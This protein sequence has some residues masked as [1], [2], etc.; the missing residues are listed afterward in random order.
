MLQVSQAFLRHGYGKLTMVELAKECGFTRRALYYYFNSKEE[1][2]RATVRHGNAQGI[3]LGFEAGERIRRD[4]GSA[5]EIISEIMNIRYGTTRRIVQSSPHTVEL[6]AVAF[7]TSRDIMIEFAIS[8]QD[9]LE[10][11]IISL[12]EDGLLR[13]TGALSPKQIAQA[14]ADGARGVNQALPPPPL[15]DLSERYRLMCQTILFGSATAPG[16][17]TRSKA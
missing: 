14:L 5:V 15:A 11:L 4:G 3:Q 10:R 13:L 9:D 12:A 2:Y 17:D 1:A 16:R 7:M 8:F 6:N